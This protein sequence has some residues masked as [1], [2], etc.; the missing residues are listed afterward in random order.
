MG[1]VVENELLMSEWNWEKNNELRLYPD[2]LKCKSNKKAWWKC[3]NGHEWQSCICNRT[4]YNGKCPHCNREDHISNQEMKVYYYIKVYFPDAISGYNNKDLKIKELDVFIPSLNIGIEY[5]GQAWHKDV[6]RDKR[7]D[8]ACQEKNVHL[9]RIREPKCP[10]YDSTCAFIYLS[11]LS[12][13]ALSN[14]IKDILNLLDVKNPDVDPER[15]FSQI[16]SLFFHKRRTNSLLELFPDIAAEWHPTK[17]GKLKP[18]NVTAHSA[19]KVWWICP[20]CGE[21]WFASVEKRVDG[22]GCPH[23]ANIN[24]SKAQ[25][26]L[27]FCQELNKIFP[28]VRVAESETGVCHS[29]ISRCCL[30]KLKFAGQQSGTNDKLHWRYIEDQLMKDGTVILGALSLG[31]VLQE[32]INQLTT[33]N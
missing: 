23:C 2:K 20:V 12:T 21:E 14:A 28:S 7:K 16:E 11:D 19:K 1:Y 15:D 22:R 32:D 27:V 30:E 8:I 26:K 25:S 24:R 17:N 3:D 31:Y 5:D 29:N 18:E 33:Q 10:K 6:E 9:I 4:I 13:N